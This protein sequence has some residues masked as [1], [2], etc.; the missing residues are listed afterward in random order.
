MLGHGFRTHA[1]TRPGSFGFPVVN[2]AG[3]RTR[4]GAFNIGMSPRTYVLAAGLAALLVLGAGGTA[5][6]SPA[7]TMAACA[8]MLLV[9]LPHGALDLEIIKRERV[10]GRLGMVALLFLYVGLAAAMAAVWHMAPVTALAIFLVVSVVHFS[11]DWHEL[12]SPFLAQ[13]MAIALLTAPTLLHLAE[14]EQLFATLSGQSDAAVV[15]NLMLLLAPVSVAVASVAVWT[16]WR[17]GFRNQAVVGALMLVGMAVLPPVIGFALF[18]C[19]YHS[20]RHLG[21]ALS[22]VAWSPSS[23]WIVPLVT[24]AAIGIAVALFAGDVRADLPA[25]FVAAS[26]MTLS[27]LTVPHMIVPAVVDALSLRR[28]SALH[29]HGRIKA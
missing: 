18:F 28:S 14:L 27:L 24:L 19:L 8:A 10:T 21:V 2:A 23:W 7:S 20:P 16:L 26:F 4:L 11:E 5:L 13:G 9:G 29:R 12:R 1:A 15:A 25:Q 6:G 3:T 17:N 22:R